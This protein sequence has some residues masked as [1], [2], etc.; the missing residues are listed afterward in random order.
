MRSKLRIWT[1]VAFLSLVSFAVLLIRH[2]FDS[3]RRTM[4]A[5]QLYNIYSAIDQESQLTKIPNQATSTHLGMQQSWRVVVYNW[6]IANRFGG[7]YKLNESYDSSSNLSAAKSIVLADG[8]QFKPGSVYALPGDRNAMKNSWTSY[9]RVTGRGT[10]GEGFSTN[11]DV[12]DGADKTI[13]VV[14]MLNSGVF[15]TAPIDLSIDDNS[16]LLDRWMKQPEKIAV[17]GDGKV[18]QLDSKTTLEE[19]FALCTCNG[20]EYVRIDEHKQLSWEGWEYLSFE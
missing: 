1:A 14:L 3:E 9:L 19:F 15:W 6:M 7:L 10:Y 20:G 16:Q 8:K 2:R 4:A 17:F 12:P 13:L 5:Y 11:I 18:R